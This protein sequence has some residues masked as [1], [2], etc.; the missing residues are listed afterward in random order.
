MSSPQVVCLKGDVQG[1]CWACVRWMS[2]TS[3]FEE[4][5]HDAWPRDA[6]E[7]LRRARSIT[8]P[9]SGRCLPEL[10]RSVLVPVYATEA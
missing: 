3:S 1:R 10:D 6:A 2:A 8:S 4:A 9:P 7:A 5:T